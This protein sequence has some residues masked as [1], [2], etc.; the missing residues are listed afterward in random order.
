MS[1]STARRRLFVNPPIQ[2]TLI[3]RVALYWLLGMFIQAVLIMVLSP[4]SGVGDDLALRTQQFW[5]HLNLIFISSLLTL[6]LL[7]LDIIKLSHRWVGPI[8]RLRAAMQALAMAE[9]V[10]PLTFRAGD[11][12]K[13]V[14]EDFNAVLAR[15]N[16]LVEESGGKTAAREQ[17]EETAV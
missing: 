6:P 8:Y 7:V 9:P 11:Y 2:G 12:W 4:A 1:K 13:D 3:S 5:S 16:Y 10:T 17:R 15:V 14:A